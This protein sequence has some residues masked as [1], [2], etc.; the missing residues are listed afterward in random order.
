MAYL[1]INKKYGGPTKLPR[2]IP[3][4]IV[5]WYIG[6]PWYIPW[7]PSTTLTCDKFLN[8]EINITKMAIFLQ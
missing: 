2:N 5:Y 4:Y 7:K 3:W 6:I 1:M 8:G